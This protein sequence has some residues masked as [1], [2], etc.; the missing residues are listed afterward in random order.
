MIARSVLRCGLLAASLF[1]I[2]PPAGACDGARCTTAGKPLQLSNFMR[3]PSAKAVR[4]ANAWRATAP[5]SAIASRGKRMPTAIAAIE[6]ADP[7]S[8]SSPAPASQPA[9]PVREVASDEL[10]EIDLA[11]NAAPIA[12]EALA[13]AA[14]RAIQVVEASDL[15]DIDRKA[16]D[17]RPP[18]IPASGSAPASSNAPASGNWAVR[19][20]NM[21]YSGMSA[22]AAA[23]LWLIG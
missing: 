19:V 5:K 21:L 7:P 10:N 20:W 22:V 17:L 18:G 3:H 16:R 23:A 8:E 2:A 1:V 4:A 13:M 9:P 11:A 14:E 12:R 15:N 6:P